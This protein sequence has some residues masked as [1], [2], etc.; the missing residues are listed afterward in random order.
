MAN[1]EYVCLDT[2]AF[3]NALEKKDHL[4]STFDSIKED[5]K[6]T[7]DKLLKNWEGVGAEAFKLDANAVMT[8][9]TGISDILKIMCDTLSDCKQVFEEAD[10]SLGEYNRNPESEA[11]E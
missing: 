6:K 4:I 8:N 2:R 3:D 1:S 9:I 10:A 7:V 11:E 5:Y